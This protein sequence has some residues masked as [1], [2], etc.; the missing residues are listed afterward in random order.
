MKT[1]QIT[2]EQMEAQIARFGEI[3]PQSNSYS[4]EDG[5]RRRPMRP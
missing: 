1:V 4:E 3:K 5:S 2:P